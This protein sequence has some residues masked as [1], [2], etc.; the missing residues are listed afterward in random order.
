MRDF[1]NVYNKWSDLSPFEK[2]YLYT[3]FKR[4]SKHLEKPTLEEFAA[5]ILC[6]LY[7]F[8]ESTWAV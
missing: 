5:Y 3:K 8:I 6:D 4:L 7:K 2:Y 1:E